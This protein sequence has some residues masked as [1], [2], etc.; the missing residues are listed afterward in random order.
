[1]RYVLS[2]DVCILIWDE[3]QIYMWWLLL[4]FG[5][6]F[7]SY[8]TEFLLKGL[9]K[10][11]NWNIV[12]NSWDKHSFKGNLIF[13]RLDCILTG[14]NFFLRIDNVGI[15]TG[16]VTQTAFSLHEFKCPRPV[17]RCVALVESIFNI[18][19]QSVFTALRYVYALLA[20]ALHG[21][22]QFSIPVLA[23]SKINFVLSFRK[24]WPET[25]DQPAL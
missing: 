18:F 16:I 1:M 13:A 9:T 15:E 23:C 11:S 12:V 19:L 20:F 21:M 6:I 22:L 10:L 3:K 25:A 7:S 5:I 17:D 4:V 2:D 24:D 14:Y 8:G